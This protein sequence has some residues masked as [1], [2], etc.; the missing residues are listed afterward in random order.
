MRILIANWHRNVTG[1]AEKYLQALLPALLHRGHEV[2][3][4]Y[5]R[6]VDRSRETVDSPDHAVLSWGVEERSEEAVLNGINKW[7]P[8]VVYIHGLENPGFEK[9]LQIAYR[10]V[11]FAHNYYGTC[12]TGNKCHSFPVIRPCERRFG[13]ACVLLHYP[14][15]CGGLNI[16]TTWRLFRQQWQRKEG[17]PR[18]NAIL[19][20]SRHMYD[21]FL[22]HGVPPGKIHLVPLPVTDTTPELA[23]PAKRLPQNRLLLIA[24]LT[25]LKGGD[26]LIHAVRK[27]SEKLGPLELTV[28]GDGPELENLRNLARETGVLADFTGWVGRE[29]KI[30]LIRRAD[31]VAVPSLWPEPFGLTGIEAGSWGVPAVG[32][33]VGGIGDWLI[34]GYSGELAQ[35]DRPMVDG[36]AEAIIRALASPEHYAKLCRGAW[37]V[38]SRFTLDAHLALLESILGAE[39]F[40]PLDNCPRV[41]SIRL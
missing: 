14:R 17:L 8:H 13:P 5:E 15:R 26:S 34:P 19:V 28:A 25:K 22:Q 16:S 35:P 37:E 38:A 31:L 20:A 9:K 10:T 6:A 21:E 4:A 23:A 40:S 33:D 36:L 30:E 3:I 7:R 11:L 24:R 12:G 29:Q 39:E 2:A 1:G 18:Y 41:G 32:F 27:A